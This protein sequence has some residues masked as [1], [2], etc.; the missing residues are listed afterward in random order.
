M[1]PLRNSSV[2][3]PPIRKSQRVAV[4]DEL[5]S[6]RVINLFKDG[7]AVYVKCHCKHRGLPLKV[8]IPPL[9]GKP[10]IF[11]VACVKGCP[12]LLDMHPWTQWD[13]AREWV[14]MEAMFHPGGVSAPSQKPWESSVTKK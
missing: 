9:A 1:A 3:T 2:A 5:K 7:G 4:S 8:V 6:E 10:R 12:V 13:E 14:W 11:Y